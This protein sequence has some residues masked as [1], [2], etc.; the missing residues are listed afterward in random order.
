MEK[1]T[2]ENTDIPNE[3]DLK[4]RI[5]NVRKEV[6]EKPFTSVESNEDPSTKREVASSEVAVEYKSEPPEHDEEN[7]EVS[8]K[9]PGDL[10]SQQ[11]DLEES[12]D[13]EEDEIETSNEIEVTDERWPITKGLVKWSDTTFKSIGSIWKNAMKGFTGFGR[14]YLNDAPIAVYGLSL[15][16]VTS[17]IAV[18]WT[19][20]AGATGIS[21]RVLAG[22]TDVVRAVVDSG[23]GNLQ[24]GKHR[25]RL[26][27]SP[28][29]TSASEKK[30]QDIKPL[31]K[32]EQDRILT[33]RV[34]TSEAMRRAQQERAK[35]V[36]NVLK[37]DSKEED[38]LVIMGRQFVKGVMVLTITAAGL[39]AVG[40]GAI[41]LGAA[42]APAAFPA[43]LSF[44]TVKTMGYIGAVVG[45]VGL[46]VAKN[47]D[48]LYKHW[49]HKKKK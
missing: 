18:P 43:A 40:G 31:S 35:T 24:I 26:K 39:A 32:E 41:F 33:E 37:G 6:G 5:R 3:E 25:K 38:G 14:S 19:V 13:G 15:L 20:I 42:F 2:G 10:E 48:D 7:V 17:V 45:I 28:E 8:E 9:K 12:K 30:E 46:V 22:I 11:V 49:F 16:A 21:L 44:A 4:E 47:L 34:D 1:F 27:K 29:S 23:E 36:K